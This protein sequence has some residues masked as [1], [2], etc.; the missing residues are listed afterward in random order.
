[1]FKKAGILF[2]CFALAQC[3][4]KID[5]MDRPLHTKNNSFQTEEHRLLPMDGSH[6]TREL[7][8]YKT[9]DGKTI[10]WGKLFRSDK[11][12]D[13][14]KID[15]AYLQNLGIKKIVDFRSE[16]E[17]AEDPNIIPT[18]I[19]YV[20]MPISVDGAMRSKIEAVLKGETDREV[21]SFLIDANKEFVT[22]YADVYENF[23]R[24]LIDE[25][26]PTLFHC[27]AGKDRAGFAAAI[28]LI[29]LGVSKE[30]VIN[31]YM[32]TNTFTQERIEEILGQI[33]LMSLYQADVEILRPLLGVEQIYIETAFRTAEDKYGSLENFIRDGLNISDEDIQK[34]RNKFLEG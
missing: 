25:D 8:G 34:L 32:K 23:L 1:M 5:L 24:G 16:Q 28:T 29:A 7:G 12:S 22:N 13:I 33:E 15:Q 2:L 19:S 10:K 11:L 9:T 14:S 4:E 17:K 21:Q 26:A 6:N 27:T 30:D 18:G 31:D 3:S 20:E